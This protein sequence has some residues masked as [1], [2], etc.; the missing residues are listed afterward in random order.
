MTRLSY[1]CL[2]TLVISFAYNVANIEGRAFDDPLSST[3]SSTN[4]S[5][6]IKDVGKVSA[7]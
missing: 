3:T 1:H 4:S 2:I 6:K 7:F 5:P